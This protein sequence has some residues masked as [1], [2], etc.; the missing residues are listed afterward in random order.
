VSI[1]AA[2]NS[3]TD[4]AAHFAATAGLAILPFGALEQ[5]GPHLPLATDTLTAERVAAELAERMDAV[6]LPAIAYGETWNNAGYPGTVSLSPATVTAIAVDIGR[7]LVHSG[8]RAFAIVNGD[9]GNRAPLTE[10]VRILTDERAIPATVL[11]Y[12]GMDDAVARLRESRPAFAGLNHAEEVETSIILAI[13][14]GLVHP[15]R[16]ESAYPD[17][18]NDF[19]VRPM[20]LHPFSPSGVFG[21]PAT[22]SAAKGDAILAATIDASEQVLRDFLATIE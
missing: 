10:A 2:D 8:A 21:D 14:P 19:G 20:Q 9:W 4:V 17:F 6:L 22:A 5:H 18:P 16:Y 7:S 1:R 3:W 12:P 15:D 13:S 11:D